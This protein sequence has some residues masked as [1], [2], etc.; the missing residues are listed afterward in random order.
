[1][2]LV[3]LPDWTISGT[4]HPLNATFFELAQRGGGV[5]T[6][7]CCTENSVLWHSACIEALSKADFSACWSTVMELTW[8]KY[9]LGSTCPTLLSMTVIMQW[10]TSNCRNR[11]ASISSQAVLLCGTCERHVNRTSVLAQLGCNRCSHEHKNNGRDDQSFQNFL[12]FFPT[13]FLMNDE[14]YSQ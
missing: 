6:C 7:C 1:M 4:A 8:I 12:Y 14:G 10:T 11:R 2:S 3:E 13:H 5:R 9:T